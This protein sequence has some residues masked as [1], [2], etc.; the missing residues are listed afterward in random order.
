MANGEETKQ[1][2]DLVDALDFP[3]V[4][5]DQ[6]FTWLSNVMGEARLDLLSVVSRADVDKLEGIITLPDIMRSHGLSSPGSAQSRKISSA[7]S[8]FRETLAAD[9]RM[10]GQFRFL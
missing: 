10:T 9:G 5:L 4:H 8:L 7:F 1:L 2:R 3:H 6:P